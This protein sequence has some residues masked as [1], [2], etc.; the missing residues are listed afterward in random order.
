MRISAPARQPPRRLPPASPGQPRPALALAPLQPPDARPQPNQPPAP[1]PPRREFPGQLQKIL[2]WFRDYKIP[3][4][5]PANAFGYDNKCMNKE[6]AMKVRAAR[7]ARPLP[8]AVQGLCRALCRASAACCAAGSAMAAAGRTAKAPPASP[9][10]LPAAAAAASPQVV[11]E[12]HH[13][14]NS[15]KSGKR[16]NDEEL[17]LI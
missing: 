14:Y 7:C 13:F 17:S 10:P 4:G 11:E 3:D 12:T 1:P 6:F 8:R 16:A 9:S 2:E 5:K 15:L